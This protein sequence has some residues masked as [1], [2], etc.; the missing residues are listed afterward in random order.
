V[1]H[2]F[3]GID[4]SKNGFHVAIY[5]NSKVTQFSNSMKG[6][7]EFEKVNKQI[8]ADALI[9]LE[10]TGGYESALLNY[11]QSNHIVTRHVKMYH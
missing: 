1:Y 8:L 3:V 4:I 2:N 10:A 5:G 7:K 9:V 11:L 6:F